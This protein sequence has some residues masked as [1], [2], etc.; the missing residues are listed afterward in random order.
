MLADL[1]GSRL[2]AKLI[3]WLFTHP[4]ERYF[5]KGL[6]NLL[7]EDSTNVSRELSR[8]TELGILTCLLVGRQK[9]Y[10]ANHRCP[11]YEELMGLAVK[12]SGIADV[13]R[14]A[15]YPLADRIEVAFIYGSFASGKQH[16]D[17][18]IDLMVVGEVGFGE[19]VL[20]T[21]PRQLKLGREINPTIYSEDE[22]RQKVRE[23]NHFLTTVLSEPRIVIVGNEDELARVGHRGKSDKASDKP[24]RDS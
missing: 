21:G 16:L 8:L 11:V 20:A 13:L 14:N 23:G 7:N 1:F 15:L 12:T 10:Q 5:V 17:S 2:R 24:A 19:V 18:D 9:F 6:G 22:F 3:A 4:D